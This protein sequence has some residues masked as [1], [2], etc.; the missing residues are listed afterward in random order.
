MEAFHAA[1]Q[2][3]SANDF[4]EALHNSDMIKMYS[5]AVNK[6]RFVDYFVT[7]PL[8]L[9]ELDV[10]TYRE[11]LLMKVKLDVNVLAKFL[12]GLPRQYACNWIEL[13]GHDYELYKHICQK[14]ESLYSASLNSLCNLDDSEALLRIKYIST[15]DLEL[16]LSGKLKLKLAQLVLISR[17]DA[18]FEDFL[19]YWA[20]HHSV[21]SE[22]YI[23]I[24]L[25]CLL[26]AVT[27][28]QVNHPLHILLID[29][30]QKRLS[31][32]DTSGLVG[33]V[34][35]ELQS[36]VAG[37]PIDMKLDYSDAGIK[38]MM[39]SFYLAMFI[40]DERLEG[41]PLT[42]HYAYDS[43]K[44]PKNTKIKE[45]EPETVDFKEPRSKNDKNRV[46]RY[47]FAILSALD[48]QDKPER[49]LSAV[50]SL[51]EMIK[52]RSI[53]LTEFNDHK[54]KLVDKFLLLPVGG[55]QRVEPNQ[56][57]AIRLWLCSMAPELV[58]TKSV[59]LLFGKNIG[60]LD[61]ADLLTMMVRAGQLSLG[62]VK[63]DDELMV[64]VDCNTRN[65]SKDL[66]L[67]FTNGCLQKMAKRFNYLMGMNGFLGE[68]LLLALACV[69]PC[70]SMHIEYDSIV[71]NLS[72]I[73]ND[74]IVHK[75]DC[76]NNL[77]KAGITCI[78]VA[79]GERKAMTVSEDYLRL[80]T[81]TGELC[82]HLVETTTGE[83]KTMAYNLI[84]VLKDNV[85]VN[86]LMQ[87]A[88]TVDDGHDS[89]D[90]KIPH[91]SSMGR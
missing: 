35:G 1:L 72:V 45:P 4:M 10:Q 87:L 50:E 26:G 5:E 27:G 40:E 73:I 88:I 65:S 16:I 56:I 29:G 38:A 80:V 58:A 75:S 37:T 21:E 57:L 9:H 25:A 32:T 15:I 62:R 42:L 77:K 76:P 49:R 13:Y 36:R 2:R 22:L 7:V 86:E 17:P 18:Y 70:L 43:F 47:L 11:Q 60:L 52:E 67:L 20:D 23:G 91:Y 84:G 19:N 64:Y 78:M 39:E 41:C 28:V 83:V 31:Y 3:E 63:L 30:V 59:S 53:G 68:R 8:K 79:L 34:I 71:Y 55:I 51:L 89:D 12:Y 46:K 54:E 74:F 66:F 90:I 44:D 85:P 82:E 24:L 14:D 33:R 81:L 61:K 48:E 69:I 6:S